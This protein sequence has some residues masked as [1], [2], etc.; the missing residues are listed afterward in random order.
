L[1]SIRPATLPVRS[2]HPGGFSYFWAMRYTKTALTITQQI[3]LLKSRGLIIADESKSEE[4]LSSV[5]YYRLRAYTY[6]FQDNSDP[7]HKFRPGIT[8]EK[9][10]DTY[11]FDRT[12]RHFTFQALERIEIAIRTQIIYNFSLTYGSHWFEDASLFINK[13]YHLD[14]L[15]DLDKEIDRSNERFIKHYK[16][17]YDDPSRPPSWMS[18]EVTSFGLLSKF[19]ENL[20]NCEEKKKVARNFKL[21]NPRILESWIHALS[22]VRNI[23]AHH[24]RLWNREFA[25]SP[26]IPRNTMDIFLA[27]LTINP[28]K[29]YF[30]LSIIAYI[31]NAT[32]QNHTF[33]KQIIGL[34]DHYPDI[35]IDQMGFPEDWEDEPLWNT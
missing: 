32:G 6:P 35:D 12:L 5:S 19:F 26:V 23:C 17:K 15:K 25:T 1:H 18:L 4:V 28:N 24:S 16:N 29:S 30:V 14:D 7:D 34:L 2:A 27:D 3:D 31:L 22:T 9:V 20:K 11:N 10:I 33:K 13:D 8:W 21:N